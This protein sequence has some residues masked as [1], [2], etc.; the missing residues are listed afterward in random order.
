M[1]FHHSRALEVIAAP[2]EFPEDTQPWEH[3]FLADVRAALDRQV[4]GVILDLADTVSLGGNGAAALLELAQYAGSVGGVILLQNVPDALMPPLQ[5]AGVDRMCFVR[6]AAT[7]SP[8]SSP[9]QAAADPHAAERE[10]R[11]TSGGILRLESDDGDRE[12]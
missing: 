3:P 7:E 10:A 8:A 12:P 4:A 1:P 9:G 11:R 6:R 5:A 2:P